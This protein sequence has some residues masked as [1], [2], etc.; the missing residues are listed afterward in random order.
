MSPQGAYPECEGSSGV[1][2]A[3]VE[4]PRVFK[5]ILYQFFRF[6]PLRLLFMLLGTYKT[7][8]S[9]VSTF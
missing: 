3:F 4:T 7:F 8:L 2:E 5:F 1:T 6:F 9:D